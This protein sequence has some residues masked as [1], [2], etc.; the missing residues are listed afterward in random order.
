MVQACAKNCKAH[1]GSQLRGFLWQSAAR[2]SSPFLLQSALA[3]GS[4]FFLKLFL[5]MTNCNQDYSRRHSSTNARFASERTAHKSVAMAEWL[6]RYAGRSIHD[7]KLKVSNQ[8]I[9]NEL[10]SILH[11]HIADSQTFIAKSPA[12]RQHAEVNSTL[13]YQQAAISMVQGRNA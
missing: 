7:Y 9:I 13:K 6:P 10:I 8:Q 2:T 12:F 3:R 11:R 5:S 1:A 4:L